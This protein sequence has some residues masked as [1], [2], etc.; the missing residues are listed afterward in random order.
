MVIGILLI[1]VPLLYT[2]VRVLWAVYF[3]KMQKTR[4]RF[5]CVLASLV[6]AFFATFTTKAFIS[7]EDFFNDVVVPMLFSGDA[8]IA[9]LF[10]EAAS[11]RQMLSGIVSSLIAP[12]LFLIYFML[13]DLISWIVFLIVFSIGKK[14]NKPAKV[15]KNPKV[16]LIATI[17]FALGNALI[18]LFAWMLPIGVY[19]SFLPSALSCFTNTD[20]LPAEEK[21][22]YEEIVTD[23]ITPINDNPTVNVFRFLG[24][25]VTAD[26]MTTFEVGDKYVGATKTVGEI[27]ELLGNLVSLGETPVEE[28]GEEQTKVFDQIL[29]SIESSETLPLVFSETV[30]AATGAW[31]EGKS[32]LGISSDALYID[33]RGIFNG[34][35]DKTI[36]ILNQD[37]R[38]GRTDLL[39][40]D[41][42]TTFEMIEV[43]IK[44]DVFLMASEG[45]NLLARLAKDG[46]VRDL[47]GVLEQNQTMSAL[48]PEITNLGM[49]AIGSTLGIDSDTS[50]EYGEMMDGIAVE[51]NGVKE[52]DESEQV[53]HVENLLRAEFEKNGLIVQD[54]VVNNYATRMVEDLVKTDEDGIDSND[55]L[56][57][58]SENSW[59]ASQDVPNGN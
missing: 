39:C 50:A 26:M 28:Y 31:L 11:L 33:E 16:T 3:R 17:S 32:F 25:S 54:S 34:L 37:T 13:F 4:F 36:L 21:A 9:G 5:F 29:N 52:M 12:V 53:A 1:L 59:E 19:A 51:L 24:G 10:S 14:K 55:L 42:D 35:M 47:I 27:S 48:V 7:S 22:A 20:M 15:S 56:I 6:A 23:Y 58:F 46:T 38:P 30:H 2:A 44:H 41:L 8:G 18:V 57:F 45:G 43:L 49:S 40:D